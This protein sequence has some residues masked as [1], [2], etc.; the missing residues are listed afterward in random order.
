MIYTLLVQSS[1][2]VG[3]IPGIPTDLGSLLTWAIRTIFLLAGFIVGYYV[4]TGALDWVQS[5]GDKEKVE[6]AR[7][8][9][10]TAIIGL[11]IL[12][13]TIAIVAL[14]ENVFGVGLGITRSIY[15]TPVGVS[16]A[17]AKTCLDKNTAA[18]IAANTV[19][20]QIVPK[21][22]G[23]VAAK[24]QAGWAC[25]PVTIADGAITASTC[26]TW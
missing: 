26:K 4:L 2:S 8:K 12:F 17:H 18:I 5:G 19:K 1:V 11:I 3:T 25:C 7:K 21:P 22:D 15:F 23:L 20:Y 24:V 9:I 10:T 16:Q 14:V 13:A 6:T